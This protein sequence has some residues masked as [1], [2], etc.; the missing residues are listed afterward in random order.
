MYAGEQPRVDANRH[1]H[2]GFKT[3]SHLLASMSSEEK[4]KNIWGKKVFLQQNYIIFDSDLVKKSLLIF[5]ESVL[6]PC[7]T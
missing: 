3:P 5:I 1:L 2:S 6:S 7:S 4:S